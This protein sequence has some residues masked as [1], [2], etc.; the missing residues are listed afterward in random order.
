MSRESCFSASELVLA[1]G[2]EWRN[3]I[4]PQGSVAVY[5]DSRQAGEGNCFLALCGEKFDA[6]DFLQS[7]VESGAGALCV[8]RDKEKSVAVTCDLPVL[9]VDDTLNAYQDIARFHRRRFATLRI[10]AVTGSVGKTSVKEMLRAIFT[11]AAGAEENV[12][13]TLGNTNNQVGVPQNLLRLTDEHRFAVL[14]MGTNHHG[15]IEPLSRCAEPQVGV[16][17][18]IAPC[19]LEFL[20]SLDGVAA[21]KSH[22]W[23]GLP[24]DGVAVF[25]QNCDGVT[26]LTEKSAGYRALRFGSEDGADVRAEFLSGSLEG[27]LFRLTFPDGQAFE[28]EWSLTGEHQAVNAAAAAAAALALGVEPAEIA[29]GLS[30]TVLPGMRMARSEHGGVVYLNDAYNANPE[31][32]AA[33][34]KMLKRSAGIGDRLILVLGDML[35]LGAFEADGHCATLALARELLP[36]SR[37]FTVGSRMARAACT[38]GNPPEITVCESAAAAGAELKKR[39]RAGDTVFLKGSRGM[40]LE[41]ALPGA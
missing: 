5:T 2:G 24:P 28:I 12:L 1:T 22:V 31:S 25:S 19:H 16:V 6:H 3:G 39:V 11:V 27:S 15:E 8:A 26:V 36:Q 23:D 13:F 34:L 40:A 33:S 14:E 30:R 9:L 37:I 4:V 32:M 21:E 17:N 20:G 29:A 18:S 7:A 41:G 10:A 38:L 35:E